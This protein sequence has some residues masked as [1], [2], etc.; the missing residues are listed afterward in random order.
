[1]PKRSNEV[2]SHLELAS[3]YLQQLR[4]HLIFDEALNAQ[5]ES[6]LGRV[7][8]LLETLQQSETLKAASQT[9]LPL[10]PQQRLAAA[11]LLTQIRSHVARAQLLLDAA[12]SFHCGIALTGP[13]VAETYSPD[14]DWQTSYPADQI[15]LNA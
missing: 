9:G 6:T 13:P 11:S 4:H 7:A 5:T 2:V 1:M 15:C 8:A 12:A 10:E 14:G 3:A